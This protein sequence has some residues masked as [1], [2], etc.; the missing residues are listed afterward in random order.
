MSEGLGRVNLPLIYNGFSLLQALL[1][2]RELRVLTCGK[3]NG[4]LVNLC[5]IASKTPTSSDF[6][7]IVDYC[8]SDD[9]VCE[10]KKEYMVFLDIKSVKR[11]LRYVPSFVWTY[12]REVLLEIYREMPPLDHM[13]AYAIIDMWHWKMLVYNS[14][15]YFHSLLKRRVLTKTIIGNKVLREKNLPDEIIWKILFY[16]PM[17]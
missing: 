15:R 4:T 3:F 9:R 6:E 2:E 10:S 16:V 7:E 11:Y 5:E 1:S 17:Q 8:D 14:I 12:E 13:S